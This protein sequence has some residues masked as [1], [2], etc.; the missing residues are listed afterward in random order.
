MD[1]TD[2]TQKAITDSDRNV[3]IVTDS[4]A[5]VPAEMARQLDITVIPFTVSIDGQLYL[6]GI[7]LVPKELY[8]RMRLEN[9]MPTTTAASLGQ[10]QQAFKACL[11]AGAQAVLYVSLSSKLSSGYSTACH[12]AKM[13]QEEFP[14]RIVEVLD[15]QLVSISQGFVAVAAA[16]AAAQGKPLAEVQQAAEDAK[17]RVGFAA[18]LETLEYLARGGRIGK[19]A[20]MLGNLIK[21]NPILSIKDG[22]VTPV[23]RVRGEYHA[24]QVIVDY[25]VQ[26]VEDHRVLYLTILEADAPEAAAHLQELALQQMQP[27]EIFHSEFTPVMGV[28]TGPGLVGLGYY[29]E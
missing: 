7:D 2:N 23:S 5:Q 19:A 15:S 27:A 12:A 21:I 24:L 25:V 17:P 26:Q 11:H 8:H 28:H 20:Y 29:Y 16:R 10:Y 3:A 14:D 22:E 18:T 9:V 6:D 1:I 13:V 4:V